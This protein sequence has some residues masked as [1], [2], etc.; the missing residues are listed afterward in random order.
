MTNEREN[1][2]SRRRLIQGASALAGAAALA[3]TL[4]P[5]GAMAAD[6]PWATPPDTVKAAEQ[7]KDFQTYGMP[8]DWANYG[9][10]LAKFAAKYSLQLKHVDTDHSSKEEI[11]LFDKEKG[12]PVALSADIGLL[13]GAVAEKQGV[14]PSYMPASAEK[15][16]AGLKAANGGWVATF[17]GVPALVVNTDLVKTLPASW[18]DLLKPEF[19]GKIGSPGDPRASGTAQAT[20]MAWAFA[21]GGDENNLKPAVDFAKKIL[22]QYS[23]SA[24]SL[25][26]VQKGEQVMRI[27]YDFNC[28]ATVANLKKAGVN[29]QVVIPGVSIYAPSAL[30]I[31]KYNTAKKDVAQLFLEFVLSDEAQIAFAKFGARPIRYVLGDLKL[32][33]DAKALWLPDSQ[34]AKVVQVKDFTKIDALKIAQIWDDQVASA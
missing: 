15:L 5:F 18:E 27:Q 2:L 14:V 29:A 6:D 23:A 30:M 28:A 19:S 31:N 10:V 8:D 1:R 34:Y 25:E 32:P 22:P 17:T 11:D 13:W 4:R 33:D 26:A 16:P 9:E 7:A 21:N 20:F 24:A 3:P 12:N